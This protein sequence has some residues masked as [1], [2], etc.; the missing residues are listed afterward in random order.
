MFIFINFGNL[1]AL[2]LHGYIVKII[3]V[4]KSLPAAALATVASKKTCTYKNRLDDQ[5]MN[6]MKTKKYTKNSN[7]K[8]KWAVGVYTD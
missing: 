6:D 1:F 5:K 8:V 2:H 3:R 7:R 4:N